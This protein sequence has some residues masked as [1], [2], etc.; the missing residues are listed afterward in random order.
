MYQMVNS[1]ALGTEKKDE[2]QKKLDDLVPIKQ[3]VIPKII[4]KDVKDAD[5]DNFAEE[6]KVNY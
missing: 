1:L 6:F 5:G 2:G 4:N 3:L